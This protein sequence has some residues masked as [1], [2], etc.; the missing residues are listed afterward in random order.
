MSSSKKQL[1]DFEMFFSL[2]CASSKRMK[3]VAGRKKNKFQFPLNTIQQYYFLIQ[4]GSGLHRFITEGSG[5][6]ILPALCHKMVLE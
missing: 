5:V 4:K 3:V 1:K 2:K 6:Y